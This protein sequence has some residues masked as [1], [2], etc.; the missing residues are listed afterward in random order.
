MLLD[1]NNP[2][3]LIKRTI[4]PILVPSQPYELEGFVNNVVF[5][6]GHIVEQDN[7]RIYYGAADE[8]MAMVE[9]SIKEI[10]SSLEDVNE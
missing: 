6:C 8:T 3:K 1:K 9:M 7:I 10:M 4:K 5:S 2:T